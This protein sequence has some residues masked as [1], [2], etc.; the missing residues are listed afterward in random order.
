[1]DDELE[2]FKT[3]IDLRAYAASHGFQLDRKESW[4]GSSVMRHPNGEKIIIKRGTDGHYIY[5]SV[6]RSDDN[7]TIID[8]VQNRTR[9]SIGAVRKELRSWIGR[10][11]APAPFPELPKTNKDRVRVEAEYARM[12]DAPCHPYLENERGIPAQLL[13]DPRFIG[14]IRID[15]RNKNA[16]FPHFDQ[17]GLCGFEIKNSRFTGFAAGATKGLWSSNEFLDDKRLVFSEGAIDSLSY[18]VL[19]PDEHTRYASIGGQLNPIQP[20]LIRAAILAMPAHSEIVA[21]MDADAEGNKLAQ[22]VRQ[23]VELSGRDDLRFVFHEPFGFKDWNDQ[24]RAK[25]PLSL[26]T[27]QLPCPSVR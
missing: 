11:A 8:F 16:V 7:G 26:P 24:L 27:V 14:R 20:E 10:D 17:Q 13:E 18:A 15:A 9:M 4:R 23:A 22:V 25:N 3:D 1:M 6:H 2:K 12:Q 19:F 21:A 5:F